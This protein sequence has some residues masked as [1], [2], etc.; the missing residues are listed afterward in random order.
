MHVLMRG[1]R[2]SITER[3][4]AGQRLAPAVRL[5]AKLSAGKA[6]TRHVKQGSGCFSHFRPAAQPGI[7]KTTRVRRNSQ[8]PDDERDADEA[9][10]D[11]N[12]AI[13]QAA[14][15]RGAREVRS[16]GPLAP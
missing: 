3:T 12:A 11:A 1:T 5:D 16:R 8:L 4:G 9:R 13:A 14:T 7:A 6:L 10:D 2:P 15:S